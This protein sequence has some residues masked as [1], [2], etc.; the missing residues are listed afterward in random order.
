MDVCTEV[1]H[2]GWEL[3]LDG[4]DAVRELPVTARDLAGPMRASLW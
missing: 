4:I 2:G 1:M 3:A